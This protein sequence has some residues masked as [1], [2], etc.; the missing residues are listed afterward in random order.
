MRGLFAREHH[1]EVEK[2]MRSQTFLNVKTRFG[3]RYNSGWSRASGSAETA[4]FNTLLTAFICFLARRMTRK[5]EGFYDKHEAWEMLGLYGGDDGGTADLNREMAEKAASMMGQKLEIVI[6]PR[7][8]PGVQFLARAYGPHVWFGESNSCCDVRRQLSKFHVT[9]HLNK[10]SEIGKLLEKCFAFSL[11]DSE[12]PVIGPFVKKVLALHKQHGGRSYVYKNLL[13]VWNSELDASSHYPNRYEKWMDELIESQFESG[14]D[15]DTFSKWLCGL[16]SI[17]EALRAPCI[18]TPPPPVAKPGKRVVAD[19]EIV[20]AAD[21]GRKLGAGG[22][23]KPKGDSQVA[24]AGT[25]AAKKAARKD[26]I[27]GN[28]SGQRRAGKTA[29]KT[30]PGRQD[31]P[32]DRKGRKAHP[33]ASG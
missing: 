18:F 22:S 4:V 21:R 10:V 32:A 5:P 27:V 30:P 25:R 7:G 20:P 14:L 9:P 15:V 31:P 24:D 26:R 28:G 19:G 12:T 3:V 33:H 16:S 2:L 8:E 23:A 1:A 13:N 11:S 17:S 29:S 6:V